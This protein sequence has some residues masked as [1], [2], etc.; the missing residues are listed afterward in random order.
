MNGEIIEVQ[1]DSRVFVEK[2]WIGVQ[3]KYL[4]KDVPDFISNAKA[5]MLKIPA[6]DTFRRWKR[7]L[8]PIR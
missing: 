8:R 1:E 5:A 2:E 4:S 6:E 3:K 7:E